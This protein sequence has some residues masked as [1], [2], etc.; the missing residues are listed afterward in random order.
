MVS[1]PVDIF[2]D[3]GNYTERSPPI[4]EVIQAGVVP[5]FVQFLM[6][7]DFPQLQVLNPSTT[8]IILV[9]SCKIDSLTMSFLASINIT[10]V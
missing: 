8:C 9:S 6:R 4:A 5:R 2:F 10:S 7:D 3:F 1:Y